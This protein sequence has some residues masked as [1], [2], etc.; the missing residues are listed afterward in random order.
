M[1]LVVD[2]G[3]TNTTLGLYEGKE[4]VHHFR[5]ES[6]RERTVDEYHVLL[7]SLAQIARVTPSQINASILASVVPALSDTVVQAVKRAFGHD[8]L[9]VGPGIKT[10]MPILYDNPK[11]V[12]ADR[13]VNAIAAHERVGGGV[14]VVDFG[15]ATTFDCVSNR[16][17]YL[18][19][20][21]APGIMIS[22][23]ALFSRAAKLPRTEIVKPPRALG[24]NTVHSMQSG[25]IYGYVG[26]V[27]G[28][29]ERLV[30]EMGYPCTVLA[31]GGL[32]PLLHAESTTIDEVDEFITL[33]GLRILYERNRS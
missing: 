6:A 18:G 15:T 3:N 13:I 26:L 21:I 7:V 8:M 30:K 20:V 23:E 4:L 5:L 10:G 31:T 12:G 32:A 28:M 29:V 14:I 24:R 16:G 11:E 1:L 25:I 9:V 22:A 33:E 2:V 27:D 17:E 19:G